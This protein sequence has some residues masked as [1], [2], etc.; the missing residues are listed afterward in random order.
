MDNEI[1]EPEEKPEELA[2]LSGL[3]EETI[4]ELKELGR[5]VGCLC[6]FPYLA[7]IGWMFGNFPRF[8]Q[9]LMDGIR[10][11]W[12]IWLASP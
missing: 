12:E 9:M 8:A 4:E 2:W 10:N 5:F 3:P 6:F 1:E 11:L 7:F